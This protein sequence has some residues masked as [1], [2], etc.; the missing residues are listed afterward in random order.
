MGSLLLTLAIALTNSNLGIAFAMIG[1]TGC[2]LIVFIFPSLFYF[3]K[4]KIG[5][6]G[7]YYQMEDSNQIHDGIEN[8]DMICQ[9]EKSDLIHNQKRDFPLRLKYVGSIIMMITGV[10]MMILCSF[11]IFS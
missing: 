9:E 2:I 5:K 7:Q 6:F 10:S 3:Q 1:S 8:F 4:Y 11:N